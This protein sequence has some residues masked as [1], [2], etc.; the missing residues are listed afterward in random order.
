M[1]R[2]NTTTE[3]VAMLVYLLQSLGMLALAA[4]LFGIYL[5]RLLQ[6]DGWLEAARETAHN[7]RILLI[8]GGAVLAVALARV[9]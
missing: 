1:L 8:T 3:E 9:G 4:G 2:L 6:G 7:A 5:T